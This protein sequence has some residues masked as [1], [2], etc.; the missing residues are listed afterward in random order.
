MI[1]AVIVGALYWFDGH[2]IP[3]IRDDFGLEADAKKMIC[4]DCA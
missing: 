1:V 4:F 2:P 3:T